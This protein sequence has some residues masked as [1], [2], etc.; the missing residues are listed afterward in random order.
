M[1]KR[2]ALIA[3]LGVVLVF[4]G[5]AASAA[6]DLPRTFSGCMLS[7]GVL[8]QD[9]GELTCRLIEAYDF[10]VYGS[11]ETECGEWVDIEIWGET[12]SGVVTYF[13]SPGKTV[14][15]PEIGAEGMVLP[16]EPIPCRHD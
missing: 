13:F 11:A 10:R 12:R 14:D 2:G 1:W 15:L 9:G 5:N 6:D 7:G 16:D 4:G 8:R 3:L